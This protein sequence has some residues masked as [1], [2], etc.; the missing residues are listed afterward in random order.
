MAVSIISMDGVDGSPRP[1]HDEP[2]IAMPKSPTQGERLKSEQRKLSV[3][4]EII[5]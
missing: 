1:A 2:K 5:S 3:G 4:L